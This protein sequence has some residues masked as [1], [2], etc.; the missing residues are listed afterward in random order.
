MHNNLFHRD[1]NI[2]FHFLLTTRVDEFLSQFEAQL[3]SCDI[4]IKRDQVKLLEVLSILQLI[5][6]QLSFQQFI[7]LVVT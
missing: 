3:H 2:A 1:Y 4:I 6:L 5:F 7:V